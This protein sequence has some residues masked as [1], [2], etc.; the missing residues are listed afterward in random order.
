VRSS[1]RYVLR[2]CC[3]LVLTQCRALSCTYTHRVLQITAATKSRHLRARS[4]KRRTPRNL[5]WNRCRRLCSS[6]LIN[7]REGRFDSLSATRSGFRGNLQ[8]FV[9]VFRARSAMSDLGTKPVLFDLFLRSAIKAFTALQP[10]V[11]EGRVIAR[12]SPSQA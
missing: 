10:L 4:I 12:E 1:R 2:C 5:G 3:Q 9:A 8:S 11:G 6:R 7:S